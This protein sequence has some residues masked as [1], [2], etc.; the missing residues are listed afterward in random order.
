MIFPML[1]NQGSIFDDT[2]FLEIRT[3]IGNIGTW[4]FWICLAPDICYFL[5]CNTK[6]A[7]AVNLFA[8]ESR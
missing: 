2:Y 7:T 5:R 6:N 3:V 8:A 1:T 4:A